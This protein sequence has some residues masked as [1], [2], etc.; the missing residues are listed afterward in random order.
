V[1]ASAPRRIAEPV[2]GHPARS[3]CGRTKPARWIL[4]APALFLPSVSPG[5]LSSWPDPAELLSDPLQVI[6]RA[7]PTWQCHPERAA[8]LHPRAHL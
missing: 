4:S 8:A 5:R 2:A 3:R 6:D 7:F 1:T